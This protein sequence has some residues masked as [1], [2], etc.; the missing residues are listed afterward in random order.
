MKQRLEQFFEPDIICTKIKGN[1]YRMEG[2]VFG[3]DF[4]GKTATADKIEETMMFMPDSVC[5]EWR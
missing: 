2:K 5:I 4:T 1:L 3:F